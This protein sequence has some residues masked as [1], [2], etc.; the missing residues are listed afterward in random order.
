MMKARLLTVLFVFAFALGCSD[1]KNNNP[2]VVDPNNTM[3][4]VNN[5][6]N[7]NNAN[8]SNNVN[9]S[10]NANNANNVNNMSD[11]DIDVSGGDGFMNGTWIV[12]NGNGDE[13][14]TIT[15]LHIDGQE[16][17]DTGSYSMTVDVDGTPTEFN[18][19]LGASRYTSENVFSTSW[20]ARI[21]NIAEEW[22]VSEGEPQSDNEL[23]GRYT[24]TY[25]AQFGAVTLERQQ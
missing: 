11:M 21:D 12:R 25:Q 19:E 7:T 4:N 16:D 22:I 5:A 1:D 8:N 24:S 10:N 17:I 18:G 13:I 20:T 23:S 15:M 6:N 9:N 2:N 3:N 14:A